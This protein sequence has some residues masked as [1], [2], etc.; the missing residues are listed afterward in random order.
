MGAGV[1]GGVGGAVFLHTALHA[2]CVCAPMPSSQSPV[3]WLQPNVADSLHV[4]PHSVCVW[5]PPLECACVQ[6]VLAA[7]K[8]LLDV[9]I[10]SAVPCV[11]WEESSV[12]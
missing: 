1:G 11:L 4:E 6:I 3:D 8:V 10:A 2:A 9:R 5:L 12:V 7:T